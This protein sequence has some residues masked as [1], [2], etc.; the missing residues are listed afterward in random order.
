[1]NEVVELLHPRFEQ[2]GTKVEVRGPLPTI[3]ADPV[4]LR[5]VFNNLFTNAMRYNDK[6]D[7]RII[8]GEA[9]AS[10]L[11][12]RNVNNPD[13]F[14]VF[15]VK[16]NGIGIDPKHHE[17]IFRIFRRLHAQDKYGGGTGA[18]LA[19]TKKMVERHGGDLWVESELGQGATFYFSLLKVI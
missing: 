1:V 4:R 19:I 7:R 8:V 11:L 2:T 10:V 3:G 17:S 6:P 5:E 13:D 16:D 9:P 15:Y 14:Y 12:Q 18:G